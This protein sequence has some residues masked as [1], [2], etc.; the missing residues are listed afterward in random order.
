MKTISLRITDETNTKIEKIM[1]LMQDK[2]GKDVN[3]SD[4]L[5]HSVDLAFTSLT[6]NLV[7]QQEFLELM[8]GYIKAAYFRIYNPIINTDSYILNRSNVDKLEFILDS[9]EDLYSEYDFNEVRELGLLFDEENS[10][11][12][13]E[14]IRFKYRLLPETF[15][16]FMGVSEDEYLRLSDTELA[17]LLAKK[18]LDES[19]KTRAQIMF[20]IDL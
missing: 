8:K 2:E 7:D 18:L 6:R 14:L 17:N 11:T 19:F 9:I 16:S 20:N 12:I 13:A 10:I 1:K 15:L 5:R 4:V 3:T